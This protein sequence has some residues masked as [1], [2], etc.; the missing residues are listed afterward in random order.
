MRNNTNL[1]GE[2]YNWGKSSHKFAGLSCVHYNIAKYI[3]ANVTVQFDASIS[4]PYKYL[5][6][7]Q[8]CLCAEL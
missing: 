7:V 5:N 1:N 6:I 4:P 3:F 8:I 2:N